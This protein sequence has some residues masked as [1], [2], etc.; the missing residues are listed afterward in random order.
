MSHIKSHGSVTLNIYVKYVLTNV[1]KCLTIWLSTMALYYSCIIFTDWMLLVVPRRNAGPQD[2][3]LG[4]ADAETSGRGV[5]LWGGL[6][7]MVL[8]KLT[9]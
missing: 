9:T 6:K 1:T 2:T 7:L 4:G 3:S 5:S 8:K